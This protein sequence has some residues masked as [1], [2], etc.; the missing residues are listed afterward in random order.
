MH[1]ISQLIKKMY[2]LYSNL[3]V[4]NILIEST[5]DVWLK[6]RKKNQI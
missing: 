2:E 5:Y 6:K 4:N 3:F 1:S